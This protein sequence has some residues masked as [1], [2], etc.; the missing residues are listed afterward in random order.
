MIVDMRYHVASLVAVFLAL[1]LGIIIGAN[2]GVSVNPHFEQQISQLEQTY[3]KIRADQK[4]I[5][6]E[7]QIKNSELEIA[8]QFQNAIIPSLISNRLIGKRIAVIRTND[9][10]DFKYAKQLVT[11]LR[12]TGAD[13]TSITSL[14]KVFNLQDPQFKTELADAFD[15]PMQDDKLFLESLYQ[16]LVQILTQGNGSSQLLFLH[17]KNLVELWGDYNRGF[18]DT[19][20]IFGG[21]NL[22]ESNHQADIDMY[23]L[24]AIRKVPGV[25]V[26]GV[27]PSQVKESYMRL[28]Q[29]KCL[30]T[31]DNV[32]TPPGQVSL[33]YLIANGKRGNYGVKDTARSLIPTTL[34]INY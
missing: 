28:Y 6:K 27:E 13:I 23:L 15:L 33:V 20:I 11:I 7:M 30:G 5:E 9:S 34:K 3:S 18:V 21:A 8:R 29:S 14:T 19:L 24:E 16:R 1:G 32:E 10:V 17:N 31:V 2:L 12:Q 25:I 4:N 26:I 22:P